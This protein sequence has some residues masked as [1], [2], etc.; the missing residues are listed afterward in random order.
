VSDNVCMDKTHVITTSDRITIF[1]GD[2]PMDVTDL[3]AK[4][5]RDPSEFTWSMFAQVAL[6][7]LADKDW[8]GVLINGRAMSEEDL[9]ALV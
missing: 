8:Q 1:R 6:D 4:E 9:E 7:H 2:I 3:W 5:T